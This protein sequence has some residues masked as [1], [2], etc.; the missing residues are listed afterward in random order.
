MMKL[1]HW[2]LLLNVVI[3][4]ILSTVIRSTR[5]SHCDW[6]CSDGHFTRSTN[7]RWYIPA[8]CSWA[9]NV[10]NIVLFLWL[11]DIQ[12]CIYQI[13]MGEIQGRNH[14]FKDGVPVPWSGVLLPFYRKKKLDRSAKFG[15][16]GYIITLFIKILRVNLG[17]PSKLW[18]Y[19]P[20]DS[21][22]VT[23]IGKSEFGQCPQT[24]G[25]PLPMWH[26][27]LFDELKASAWVQTGALCDLQNKP[28]CCPPKLRPWTRWANSRR[29]PR[30]LVC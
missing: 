14:V 13:L 20:P 21:P 1:L 27:T 29:S 2:S 15:A 30:P 22:V 19:R 4:T 10:Y 8:K 25:L 24:S 5:H 17:G 3:L 11:A 9:T 12:N 18:G 23:P 28:K 26:E 6:R 7:W 16:I